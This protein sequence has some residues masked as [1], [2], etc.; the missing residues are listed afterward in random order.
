MRRVIAIELCQNTNDAKAVRRRLRSLMRRF[1]LSPLMTTARIRVNADVIPHSHP[2][3][4]L[5]TRWANDSPRLLA[6]LLHEQIHWW[7]SGRLNK[8]DRA[9]TILRTRY[10]DVPVG[11]PEGADDLYSTY[12]HLVVNWLEFTALARYL[13]IERA[14]T[15]LAGQTHYRWVY[16]TVLRDAGAIGS[17][18]ARSGL[19]LP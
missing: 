7:L 2:I 6:D 15:I 4:T 19:R 12:L 13:G 8:L 3:L 16:R 18:L 1:D 10:R 11:R 14:R 17:I 9:L 5:N